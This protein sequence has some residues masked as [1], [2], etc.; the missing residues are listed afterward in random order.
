MEK[1]AVDRVTIVPAAYTGLLYLWYL[2]M[3]IIAEAR[4]Q[5]EHRAITYIIWPGYVIVLPSW[6]A[7]AFIPAAATVRAIRRIPQNLY[8]LYSWTVSCLPLR[9]YLNS[10]N[11]SA[12][13]TA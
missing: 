3:L 9:M 8:R 2:T 11:R 5:N 1:I 10:E 6:I 12:L 13:R 7:I 4:L